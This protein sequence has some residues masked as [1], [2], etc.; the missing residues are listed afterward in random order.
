[1]ICI[2]NA[3]FFYNF[4][5]YFFIPL[6]LLTFKT[7]QVYSM[8]PFG[9]V[10]L[11]VLIFEY[12]CELGLEIYMESRTEAVCRLKRVHSLRDKGLTSASGVLAVVRS[13][14]SSVCMEFSCC[15]LSFSWNSAIPALGLLLY[16]SDEE[17]KT[18]L[19]ALM[20]W[21]SLSFYLGS[22]KYHENNA[23]IYQ[24]SIVIII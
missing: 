18:W 9:Y 5:D 22:V 7:M 19:T 17:K 10:N 1:M 21:S 2:Y 4:R 12:M 23:G 8:F 13:F 14:S 15:N 16:R 6:R 20:H 3:F 11:W 24:S